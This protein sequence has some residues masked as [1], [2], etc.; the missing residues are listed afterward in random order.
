MY[1]AYGIYRF[2]IFVKID[3][4]TPLDPKSGFCPD[5]VCRIPKGT[6]HRSVLVGTGAGSISIGP[7]WPPTCHR[8]T[9]KDPSVDRV[10]WISNKAMCT[11]WG[12]NRGLGLSGSGDP[13]INDNVKNRTC[14]KLRTHILSDLSLVDKNLHF[15]TNRKVFIRMVL[16][17]GEMSRTS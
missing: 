12:S 11:L 13:L 3:P 4:Q 6:C 7:Q 16:M 5:A 2:F 15:P 17:A 10:A 14:D 8:S 9:H 1:R